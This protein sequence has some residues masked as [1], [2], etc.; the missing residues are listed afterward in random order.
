MNFSTHDFVLQLEHQQVLVQQILQD[1]P[2]R[3]LS[4]MYGRPQLK[5][6]FLHHS[7][8]FSQTFHEYLL[9]K[10]EDRDFH[11]GLLDL[12]KLIPFEPLL[13]DFLIHAHLDIFYFLTNHFQNPSKYLVLVPKH[14]R[15]LHQNQT[16]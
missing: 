11:L 5:Q 3:E 2:H 13:T 12:H 1:L 6:L 9:L 16:F 14:Q 4:R 15:D 7:W 10:L 8:P